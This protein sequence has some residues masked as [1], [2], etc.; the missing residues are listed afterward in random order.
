MKQAEKQYFRRIS[1]ILGLC[2]ATFHLAF[3]Q[4]VSSLLD[5]YH[6]TQDTS[7]L[8]QA[9]RLAESR[10]DTSGM[11]EA[12]RY[13]AKSYASDTIAIP[14]Y[15]EALRLFRKVKDS[16]GLMKTNVNIGLIYYDLLELKLAGKHL[17]ESLSIAEKMQDKMTI[18]IILTNLGAVYDKDTATLQLALQSYQK[19]YEISEELQDTIGLL[20]N[21][22]NLGVVYEKIN[23]A[24]KA[25]EYYNRALSF[26]RQSNNEE[27][28]CRIQSNI[29]SLTLKLGQ[30]D[31]ALRLLNESE[32]SCNGANIR[33]IAYRMSLL[34]KAEAG[35]GNYERA[36]R[37]SLRYNAIND[38]L[39]YIEQSRISSEFAAKYESEKQSHQIQILEKDKQLQQE[40]I[41][42]QSVIRN[43]LIIVAI[44]FGGFAF[45]FFSQRNKIAKEQQKNE[46]LLLNILPADIAGELKSQGYSNARQHDQVTVIFSDFVGFTLH[47]ELMTPQELVRELDICFKAFDTIMD[48][49]NIEKI[50]TIGDAYLA[51]AGL[52]KPRAEHTKLACL[53]A[54]DMQAFISQRKL[55][56][57]VF[58]VRIGIHSGPV[59]AGIVGVKKYAFDIWGDTVNIAARMEQ[60]SHPGRIN[61]SKTS[62][63][64]IA[65]V[66]DCEY[67]GPVS[68]KN[69]GEMDM[70]FLNKV[71]T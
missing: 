32:N 33:M 18:S 9:F 45:V 37:L 51:V 25:I 19:A 40:E 53:A 7:Y 39:Y 43:G 52:P 47:G 67:R 13:L 34:S 49:Y 41:S 31:K 62:Y 30:Y 17:E 35:V 61:L 5:K 10:H 23:Q 16:T 58:D 60:S 22:N 27:E 28:S 42:R 59:V 70:Y 48:K 6:D 50:K 15:H 46:E 66:F 57:G 21:S 3:G 36:Y 71:I 24:D 68:V 2:I 56:G 8:Y 64:M 55:N 63:E 14:I 12:K 29:A 38:S 69:K 65:N 44:L 4:N 54:L 26:A 20:S 1:F 11:G